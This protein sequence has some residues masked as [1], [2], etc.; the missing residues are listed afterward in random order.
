M[1]FDGG[2]ELS[3]NF[4][5]GS[6]VQGRRAHA[7]TESRNFLCVNIK[8]NDPVTRR[9]LQYL[10]MLASKVV[11]LVRDAKT[12][13]ILRSPPKEQL[14]LHREKAGF[15]RASKNEWVVRW[16]VSEKFFEKGIFFPCRS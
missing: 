10:T 8:R 7:I 9:Y 14:W 3:N 4:S 15:G 2:E 16:E 11:L 1:Q 5:T 13:K 6:R 12:S